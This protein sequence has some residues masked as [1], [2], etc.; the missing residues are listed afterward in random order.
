MGQRV[1]TSSWSEGKK[2]YLFPHFPEKCEFSF[3]WIYR[4]KFDAFSDIDNFSIIS[5][6]QFFDNDNFADNLTNADLSAFDKFFPIYRWPLVDVH[7]DASRR[8]GR[9]G[10]GDVDAWSCRAARQYQSLTLLK[11]TRSGSFKILWKNVV[12]QDLVGCEV[13]CSCCQ[14]VGRGVCKKMLHHLH[15]LQSIADLRHKDKGKIWGLLGV[16]RN[17]DQWMSGRQIEGG[18]RRRRR[19][20]PSTC[21]QWRTRCTCLPACL[22]RRWW[23]WRL[24]LP[25]TPPH[26]SSLSGH[27]VAL[28][29]SQWGWAVFWRIGLKGERW[30]RRRWMGKRRWKRGEG[31][32]WRH[33]AGASSCANLVRSVLEHRDI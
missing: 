8:R 27:P 12:H 9:L 28:L 3:P 30:R 19:L 5:K 18:G 10:V 29:L 31:R 17:S 7:L 4:T 6:F 16:D 11:Q 26:P 32:K 25:G 2:G 14:S 23:H 21:L 20:A 15:P 22:P 33:S 24:L 13:L 1:A